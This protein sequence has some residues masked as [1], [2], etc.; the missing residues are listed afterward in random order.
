VQ[1][2]DVRWTNQ[3]ESATLG[4]EVGGVVTTFS[5]GPAG[6]HKRRA[7]SLSSCAS[8][9]IKAPRS[10]ESLEPMDTVSKGIL[11]GICLQ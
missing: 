8:P 7:V 6:T 11:A 1:T 9:P 3:I 2:W 5:L 4:R 10:R